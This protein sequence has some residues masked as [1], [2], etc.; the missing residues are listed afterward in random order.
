MQEQLAD[1]SLNSLATEQEGQLTD[2]TVA[3]MDASFGGDVDTLSDAERRMIEAGLEEIVPNDF[4]HFDPFGL[5]YARQFYGKAGCG[6]FAAKAYLFARGG[7]DVGACSRVVASRETRFAVY[8]IRCSTSYVG[9]TANVEFWVKG[10]SNYIYVSNPAQSCSRFDGGDQL[11]RP[12][13][14]SV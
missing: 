2:E 6:D 7:I 8:H 13:P 3:R 4:D 5:C 1:S 9:S 14:R 11:R 10:T 12:L